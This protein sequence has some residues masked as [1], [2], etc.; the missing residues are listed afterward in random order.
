MSGC[1]QGVEAREH[2]SLVLVTP[3]HAPPTIRFKGVG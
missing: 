3:D 2:S 1:P